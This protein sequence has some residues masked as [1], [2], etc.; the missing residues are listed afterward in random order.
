MKT[1][2]TALLLAVAASVGMM[3]AAIIDGTCGENLTWSLNTKDSTLTITGSGAMTS[4]PWSEYKSYI[5]YVT[6]HEGVTTINK[7]AFT[8]CT[9]LTSITIP[10]SVTSI[11]NSAF[12][13]TGLTKVNITDI[14]AWCNISFKNEEGSNPLS[15]A[16]HLYLNGEEI[17]NL[18]IP[19]SVISIGNYAFHGWTGLAA[20]EIPNSVTSIGSY[21]FY[22][23][24]SLNSV[25]IP[26]SVT[27]IGDGA[28]FLCK[29]LTSVTIPN[30]VTS[31]QYAVFE[32]CYSLSSITIPNSVTSIGAYAFTA[33]PI[34]Q[35]HYN[36]SV[37][38][39]LEKTWNV[40]QISSNYTLYLDNELV[41]DVVIPN[42]VTNIKSCAFSGCNSL[43]AVTIPKSITSIG[44][45][46]FEGCNL[47]S[48][49]SKAITPPNY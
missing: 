27:T 36:G 26:N 15:I 5:A 44:D 39:W 16:K 3:H 38:E 4:N 29:S 48:V 6:L 19:N 22:K 12:S 17:T 30:G 23:C 35:I 20:I 2:I 34:S 7:N 41:E 18:V 21:A 10:N 40:N 42:S 25:T 1:K 24:E 13:G 37:L 32:L 11:G 47:S 14:A 33:C 9:S 8:N 43:S 31:I 28:F 45:K 49:T 46:A